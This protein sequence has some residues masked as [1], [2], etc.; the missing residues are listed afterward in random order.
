MIVVNPGVLF[1]IVAPAGFRILEALKQASNEL[2]FTLQITSACDGDHSGL[3]DPHHTGEA[4]D[5]R[6]HG[7]TKDE[8]RQILRAVMNNLGSTDAG[9]DMP[10]QL[11]GIPDSLATT[12]FFG[13]LEDPGSPNEHFHFQRRKGTS[14]SVH[15]YLNS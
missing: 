5:V 14:Y 4:Y 3:A 7:F 13:F 9:F 15:E 2:G 1:S 12:R 8:Q 11:D 6:S 10:Q